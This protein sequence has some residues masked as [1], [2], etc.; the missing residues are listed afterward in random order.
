MPTQNPAHS[1]VKHTVLDE[2]RPADALAFLD[3]ACASGAASPEVQGNAMC[4][5]A[6]ADLQAQVTATHAALS[7]RGAAK[8]G[9]ATAVRTQESE[10]AAATS[11][12]GTYEAAVDTVADGSAA[13]ITKA[14]LTARLEKPPPS[15]LGTVTI[16]KTGL[17]KLPG[18][19]ILRWP[20]V[21]RATNYAVEVNLTP[22]TPAGPWTALGA[23]A[24]RRRVVTT[25]APRG[26][27]LARVAAI[28]SDGTQTAW[29]DTVLVTTR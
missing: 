21:P 29:S 7:A 17:G 8:I 5:Q 20:A 22:Q 11:A 24:S 16:V 25:P 14:G 1:V 6:L 28:G 4:K 3:N 10:M 19:G 27:L 13:V 12:L 9:L 18:E 2:N 23:G 15:T 26:E